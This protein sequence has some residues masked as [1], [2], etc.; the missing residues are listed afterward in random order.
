[1]SGDA[2]WSEADA[3][4]VNFITR[5]RVTAA[6]QPY[7]KQ[8]CEEA[9]ALEELGNLDGRL[10][11]Y[12]GECKA[13]DWMPELMGRHGGSFCQMLIQG[14][15]SMT[16]GDCLNVKLSSPNPFTTNLE[17]W[18]KLGRPIRLATGTPLWHG[19]SRVAIPDILKWGLLAG[20][21]NE[22]DG[23]LFLWDTSHVYCPQ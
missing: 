8:H 22:I 7:N 4:D 10:R 6:G 2:G 19:T 15:L 11:K 23:I 21:A 20:E 18:H 13:H 1:M 12:G 9:R 3:V 14:I 16:S 5:L 17:T